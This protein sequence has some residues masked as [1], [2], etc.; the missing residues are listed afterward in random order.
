M[1]VVGRMQLL[2][3]CSRT[4][5]P[6]TGSLAAHT[7]AAGMGSVDLVWGFRAKTNQAPG[8]YEAGVV[9]EAISP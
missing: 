2:R 5:A 1:P 7:N 3:A 9:F 4:A 8:V 6:A